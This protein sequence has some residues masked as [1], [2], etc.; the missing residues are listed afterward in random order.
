MP[1]ESAVRGY[2]NRRLHFDHSNQIVTNPIGAGAIARDGTTPATN[3]LSLGGFNINNVADPGADQDA[4]TKSYVD[5]VN[6]ATDEI[7]NNRDADFI[8]PLA[9]GN[10]LMY[11]GKF[12]MYTT[13]ASGGTFSTGNTLTG[14]NS[15]ATGT[16]IDFVQA[17]IPVYGIATRIT[18]TLTSGTNFNLSDTVNN[19]GGVTATVF[20]AAIPAIGNAVVQGSSDIT[21]TADR[22]ATAT[23]LTFNIA[24]GSI[25]N[26][27][28]STT[29]AIQQSKLAMNAATTRANAVGIT[30]ADLG[31]ASFDSGDFTVTNGF[32]TLSTSGVDLSDLPSLDQFQVFGRTTAGTGDA[33]NISFS[34]VVTDGGGIV[35]GDFGS[36]V[37]EAATPGEALIKT[38]AGAYALSLIH[39]SEPT[40]PY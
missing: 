20:D 11:N 5:A 31:L 25:I 27:D 33:H 18:Y 4:A 6:Y 32:V 35:D 37:A 1:T 2:V 30:Q 28:I 19:G 21:I 15:G 39:I 13:P 17:S 40:R 7:R 22:D 38:G 10:L 34:S 3:S 26:A 8:T 12:I 24:T 36:E 29:A 9:A 14:S 23:Q 16:I